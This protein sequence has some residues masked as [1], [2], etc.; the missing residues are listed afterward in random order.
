[1]YVKGGQSIEAIVAIHCM[2]TCS[3][4]LS[5]GFILI[6]DVE[7]YSIGNHNRKLKHYINGAEMLMDL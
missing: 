7:C 2:D 1:M 3:F 5:Y 4:V 6:S